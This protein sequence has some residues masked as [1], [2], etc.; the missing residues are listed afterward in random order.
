MFCP[1]LRMYVLPEN[2]ESDRGKVPDKIIN[3]LLS[4]YSA[5]TTVHATKNSLLVLYGTKY[6]YSL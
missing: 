2:K 1:C 6:V 3:E 5:Y 4:A